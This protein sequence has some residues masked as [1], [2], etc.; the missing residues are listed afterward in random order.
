IE[1]ARE[2]GGRVFVELGPDAVLATLVP[3][4][5][6]A[7]PLQRAGQTHAFPLALATAHTHGLPVTWPTPAA[8]LVDLPTYAFQ[9]ESYWL[10]AAS[11]AG[12]VVS[13]GQAPAGHGL[14]GAA[15]ALAEDGMTVFTGRLSLSTH[16]WLADH[17]V[18]G[19][20]LVPGT[21]FVELA[22]HAGDYVGCGQLEDLTVEAPLVLG[23]RSSVTVQVFVGE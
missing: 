1:Q 23:E 2:L 18:G 15:V 17:V 8:A 4:D 22:L 3:D 5:T 10:H 21:A 12:D 7:I 16:P 19:S 9:Q 14:L 20:V 13:L 6:T 11:G